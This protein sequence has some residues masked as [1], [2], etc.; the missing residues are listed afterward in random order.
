GIVPNAAANIA[1]Y[2]TAK[3]GVVGLSEVLHFELA[4]RGIGVSVLCPGP[5]ETR[6]GGSARNRPAH[7]GGSQEPLPPSAPPA[8]GLATAVRLPAMRDPLEVAEM[9]LAAV[10]NNHL[11]VMTHREYRDNEVMQRFDAIRAAFDPIP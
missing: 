6:L 1:P 4:P 10:R 8:S 11:Y 9:A 5:V 3:Y 7:L 2:V